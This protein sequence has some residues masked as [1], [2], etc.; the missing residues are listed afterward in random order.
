M[1]SGSEEAFR[2]IHDRYR[3]RMLAYAR[4]MLAS[5]PADPEDVVQEVFVRAYWGLR[6]SDRQLALRAW[7]YRIAHN[8]CIDELRR[9]QAVASN[10]GEALVA[11]PGHGDPVA[12]LEQRDTL[13]RLIDD[14]RRLPDQQRSALLMR[15]LAGMT[16]ADVAGALSVSVPAVKSLLVRAR[17]GLA[18][19][20]EARDTAC[21]VIREDLVVAHDRGVRLSG[22]SRRHL[23]DCPSCREFRSEVRGVSR[24]LAA[25][26]PVL[27]PLGVVGK[28]LG[29]GGASGTSAAAGSGA[30]GVSAGSGTV[31][32]GGAAI[33]GGA[34][35][36]TGLTGGGA[37]VGAGAIVT[38]GHVATILAAAVVTAGGAL[39]LQHIAPPPP[40]RTHHHRAVVRSPSPRRPAPATKSTTRYAITASAT[41]HTSTLAGAS[42]GVSHHSTAAAH[43]LSP[44]EIANPDNL[45]LLAAQT[46]AASQAASCTSGAASSSGRSTGAGTDGSSGAGVNS[47]TGAAATA[48]SG[49]AG[50]G[51]GQTSSY[52]ASEGGT[53]AIGGSTAAGSTGSASGSAG[54]AS[55]STGSAG[56]STGSASGLTGSAGGPAGSATGAAGSAAASA[57]CAGGGASAGTGVTPTLGTAS[58]V[59]SS[60]ALQSTQGA[61][62][63]ANGT[64]GTNGL[65]SSTGAL[66]S[67]GV[68]GSTGTQ[69]SAGVQGSTGTQGSAD[70]QGST[71]TQDGAGAQSGTGA[72]TSG[73][74]VRTSRSRVDSTAGGAATTGHR[75]KIALVGATTVAGRIKSSTRARTNGAHTSATHARSTRTRST[76]STHASRSGGAPLTTSDGQHH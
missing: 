49:A 21:T 62:Q 63:V 54:S 53:P 65:Q 7:L 10:Q 58:T 38:A 70:V 23:R 75:A 68:Q 64:Q 8:R 13:R 69:G 2:A 25:A 67:A 76:R 19:A 73:A 12:R 30:G 9:P 56:G 37:A 35:A 17:V 36:A 44:T 51:S 45:G 6:A 39:E 22:L 48:Q 66:G 74:T 31:I 32:G 24:G 34:V 52:A 61:G 43:A 5:S 4:Q 15:E 55:G 71:G 46:G 11:E 60:G 29:I 16:Y 20:N 3:V 57:S 40:A 42:A 27:G 50:T 47:A 26:V 18:Q 28:L 41:P 1:R 33:G 72:Q 14:V 59:A